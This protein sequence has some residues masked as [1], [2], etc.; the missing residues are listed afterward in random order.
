M[1]VC[2]VSGKEGEEEKAKELWVC[3]ISVHMRDGDGEMQRSVCSVCAGGFE[4]GVWVGVKMMTAL[5]AAE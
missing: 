4:G 1:C 3:G 2:V 5:R